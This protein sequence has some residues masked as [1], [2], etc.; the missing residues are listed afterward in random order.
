LAH[1]LGHVLL[2]HP[3]HPNEL[4]ERDPT[5][6][7]DGS[8]NDGTVLGPKRLTADEC[9]RLRFRASANGLLAPGP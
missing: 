7:L 2:D 9:A 8:A 6:L 5:R 1:E 3:F 4:G